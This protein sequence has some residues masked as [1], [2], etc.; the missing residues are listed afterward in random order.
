MHWRN[1]GLCTCSAGLLP[2]SPCAQSIEDSDLVGRGISPENSWHL[3]CP[4]IPR[5]SFRSRQAGEESLLRFSLSV[6]APKTCPRAKTSEPLGHSSARKC[7]GAMYAC[8]HVPPASS[9]HLPLFI[10]E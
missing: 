6:T 7:T 2:C 3:P 8:A 1:P 5:P 10:S 9:R 4:R